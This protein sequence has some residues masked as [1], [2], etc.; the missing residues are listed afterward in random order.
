M[1]DLVNGTSASAF[2]LMV[3]RYDVEPLGI[4]FVDFLKKNNKTK[5]KKLIVVVGTFCHF[6]KLYFKTRLMF[7]VTK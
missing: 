4:N 3:V 7:I 1:V 5:Q 2:L 6:V